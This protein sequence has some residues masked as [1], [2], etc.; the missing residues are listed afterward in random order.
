MYR[1][2]FLGDMPMLMFLSRISAT[3]IRGF[4]LLLLW[5]WFVAV[6]FGVMPLTIAHA[7]GLS[8]LIQLFTMSMTWADVESNVGKDAEN[9]FLSCLASCMSLTFGFLMSLFL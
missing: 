3:V 7:L 5:R 6:P 8:A 2:I 1:D 9:L 4:V